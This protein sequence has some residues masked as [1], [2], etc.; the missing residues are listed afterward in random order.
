MNTIC[1]LIMPPFCRRKNFKSVHTMKKINFFS[2]LLAFFLLSALSW[3]CL[4]AD[5]EKDDEWVNMPAGAKPAYM[6]IQ[7]GTMPV[8]LLVSRDRASL[9]TFVGRTGN[10][11]LEV[12]RKAYLPLPSFGNATGIGNALTGKAG[13]ADLFA[14]NATESMPVLPVS[15]DIL[16][17]EGLAGTLQPFGLS[18]EPLSIE[19]SVAKPSTATPAKKYRLFFLPDYLHPR[20]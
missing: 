17:R 16:S 10:D 8:S 5:S 20:R 12:L 19:G 2:L 9:F 14:G 15:G 3:E 18:S 13:S 6:G 4:A 1:A 7:G 11:F